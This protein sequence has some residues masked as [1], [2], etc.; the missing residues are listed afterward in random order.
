[1]KKWLII[2]MQNFQLSLN[3]ANP[4]SLAIIRI[5]KK[6]IKDR[7]CW[8]RAS[9]DCDSKEINLGS[10][11]WI[12]KQRLREAFEEFKKGIIPSYVWR[13]IFWANIECIYKY[14]G[15]LKNLQ[16]NIFCECNL[17]LKASFYWS[18]FSLLGKGPST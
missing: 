16:N 11:I 3:N 12:P 15:K 13:N 7:A 4:L 17:F 6:Q 9:L 10:I 14:L 5:K 1:M 2:C 18:I 8:D